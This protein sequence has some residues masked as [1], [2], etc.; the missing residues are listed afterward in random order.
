MPGR[1]FISYRR[2]DV[3]GDARGLRDGLSS[4]FGKSSIFMDVD[5]LLA[6]QRFDEELAR[7]LASCDV[8]IAVIGPRWMEQLKAREGTGERDYVREEIAE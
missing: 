5:N 3:P 4:R 7:A 2:D 6:G 1:I 8:F